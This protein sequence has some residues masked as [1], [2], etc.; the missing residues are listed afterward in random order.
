MSV[1]LEIKDGVRWSSPEAAMAHASMVVVRVFDEYASDCTITCGVE[2][3]EYPSKHT[4]GGALDYR[5]NH[6]TESA[7]RI[8]ANIIR[9]RLGDGFDV[10]AHGAGVHFHLHVEYDPKG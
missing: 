5:L 2:E 10:V 1:T 9:Q 7:G 3:H 8:I 6:V 4:N